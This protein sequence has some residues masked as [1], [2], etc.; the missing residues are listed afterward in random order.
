MGKS[1]LEY[2]SNYDIILGNCLD[3]LKEFDSLQF[4]TCVTSPPFW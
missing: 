4:Q 3:K 1:V 2:T